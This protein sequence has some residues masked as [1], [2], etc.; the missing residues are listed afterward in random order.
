MMTIMSNVF[1]PSTP[2]AREPSP[3]PAF[4]LSMAMADQDL[5]LVEI[6][7]GRKLTHRL[8]ELGL[9]PGVNIRVVQDNG[10]PLLISV[11]GSRI[12]IGRGMAHKLLV[13]PVSRKS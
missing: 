13:A 12:A 6:K 9:T 11:R 7:V 3:Q 8:A 5:Q 2:E 4:P 1:N 10:G